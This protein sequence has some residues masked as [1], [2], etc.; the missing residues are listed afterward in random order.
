VLGDQLVMTPS[1]MGSEPCVGRTDKYA[2]IRMF[3]R[4]VFDD[5]API[6]QHIHTAVRTPN[7]GD[8]GA[9]L[10]GRHYERH[11]RTRPAYTD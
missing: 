1:F 4:V 8:D 9:D 7:G 3:D 5:P 2:G 6:R 11:H 10:L